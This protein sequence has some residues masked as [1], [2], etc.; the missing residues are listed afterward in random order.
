VSR[1]NQD[2]SLEDFKLPCRMPARL[3]IARQ[4]LHKSEEVLRLQQKIRVQ[5]LNLAR[6]ANKISQLV[7]DLARSLKA[8]SQMD[9]I[10]SPSDRIFQGLAPN[11]T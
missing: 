6:A 1:E 2:I 4:L 7:N 11:H 5:Q 9:T 8:Q 3:W 10:E